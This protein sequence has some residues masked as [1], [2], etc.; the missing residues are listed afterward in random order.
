RQML[1]HSYCCVAGLRTCCWEHRD[2]PS[3][4]R[5]CGRMGGIESGGWAQVVAGQIMGISMELLQSACIEPPTQR[6]SQEAWAWTGTARA[7]TAVRK[8]QIRIDRPLNLPQ[9]SRFVPI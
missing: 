3:G 8:M 6:H 4:G 5:G 7:K 9:C 2:V 1:R